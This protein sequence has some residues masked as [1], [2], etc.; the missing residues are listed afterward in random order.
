MQSAMYT[1]YDRRSGSARPAGGAT[2]LSWAAPRISY[3]PRWPADMLPKRLL[4]IAG[5]VAL[6]ILLSPL[7]LVLVLVVASDGRAPLY[8]HRRVGANGR[9]FDC[10]KFRSMRPDSKE[11][12]AALLASDPQARAEWEETFKLRHDPR[13]T[14]I[15]GFLRRTSLDELPQLFNVLRGEMSLVGPRPIVREEVARYGDAFGYY[16]RCRPGL[17]GLWQVSGR[18]DTGYD[19]RVH[20]DAS[21]AAAWSLWKDV[22]ILLRTV[23]VV[24]RRSGAY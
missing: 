1:R 4:D 10:L 6:L 12:L 9:P 3:R 22:D 8:R 11:C 23:V 5:S 21:Y 20:L 19:Q 15:G 18:S 14:R 7:L 17:T 16:V 24:F 13:V 2:A